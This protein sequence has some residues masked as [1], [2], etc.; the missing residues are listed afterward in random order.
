MRSILE[1]MG[2][3][4]VVTGSKVEGHT[5]KSNSE[6]DNDEATE[7]NIEGI[8]ST[9]KQGIEIELKKLEEEIKDDEDDSNPHVKK[10]KSKGEMTSFCPIHYSYEKIKCI[11]PNIIL[12][13]S[14]ISGKDYS[15]GSDLVC[16]K[17]DFEKCMVCTDSKIDGCLD[18]LSKKYSDCD[19]KI[20]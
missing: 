18:M 20:H 12:Q 6:Q 13:V 4:N 7:K 14:F 9:G 2:D 15:E 16:C 10:K 8:K 11:S 17:Q 1:T 3:S 5:E 19:G